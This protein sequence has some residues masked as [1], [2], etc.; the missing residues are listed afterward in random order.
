LTLK[1]LQTFERL[2]E[3]ELSKV[4]DTIKQ[5]IASKP[6]FVIWLTGDLGAGKTSLTQSLLR[7]LGLSVDIPVLS[8]TFTYL[9]EYDVQSRRIAHVDLYRLVQNDEDAVTEL[10]AGRTY[11]GKIIEWPERCPDA[12]CIAPD[13]VI[14]IEIHD[15]LNRNY[16]ISIALI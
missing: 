8:P 4:T 13:L 15:T 6:S 9:T 10:F 7:S 14:A 5:L 11:W 12:D 3:S 16:R 2:P 1:L